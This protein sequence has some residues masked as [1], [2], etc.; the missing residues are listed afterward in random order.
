[1]AR[2]VTS[3]GVGQ[4]HAALPVFHEDTTVVKCLLMKYTYTL[5]LCFPLAVVLLE[6]MLR[7]THFF[8]GKHC[9]DSHSLITSTQR[10]RVINSP[11][12]KHSFLLL[13]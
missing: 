7:V 2:A 8:I 9:G 5:L 4:T 10:E 3:A 1:M 12:A 13:H 6:D 11:L